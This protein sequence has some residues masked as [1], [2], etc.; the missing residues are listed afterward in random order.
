MY[1]SGVKL[2]ARQVAARS[3]PMQFITDF[4]GDDLDGETG[5][6]LSI[7]ISSKVQNAKTIGVIH[8]EMKLVD[9]AKE[10]QA[11]MMEPTPCFY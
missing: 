9:Y 2:T 3:F 4:S 6:F 5:E 11:K 1:I 10:C 7:A 8:L